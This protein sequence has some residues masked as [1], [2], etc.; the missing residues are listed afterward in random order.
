MLLIYVHFLY[1]EFKQLFYVLLMLQYELECPFFLNKFK[2]HI[3]I[4]LYSI[5]QYL[6]ISLPFHH[7]ICCCIHPFYCN[8]PFISISPFVKNCFWSE[9]MT[10]YPEDTL[11]SIEQ[12]YLPKEN[13]FWL[14]NQLSDLLP[15]CHYAHLVF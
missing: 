15:F 5:K 14:L 11:I 4:L 1:L 12:G 3:L 7:H 9:F 8:Q 2:T 13:L 6:I 10:Q